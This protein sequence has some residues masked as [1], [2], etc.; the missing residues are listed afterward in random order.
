[1]LFNS[2]EFLLG[3]LPI[4]LG[5]FLFLA[6]RKKHRL[7]IVWMVLASLFFYGWWS[8]KY[9][10][11]IIVSIALNY[12][13]GRLF[14]SPNFQ[15]ESRRK[16]LLILGLIFNLGLLGY[17]KYSNF[18]VNNL[19]SF[20]DFNFEFAEVLLPLAISF[21]TFQQVGF[22]MDSYRNEI[23][24]PNFLNYCFFVTFFPQLIA[25]P[26][27]HHS[28]ILPQL[29]REKSLPSK[30]TFSIGLTLF[31]IGLFKKVIIADSIAVYS[32]QMFDH[33]QAG[34]V[35]GGVGAWVG[36]LCYTF[37]IYF[38]FSG[39]SDM[40]IGLGSLFNIKIPM[41]FN[42]P[43]QASSIIE[44]WRR[45]HIT[46]STFLRDYLYFFLGGNRKGKGRR[47]LNLLA[48]MVLGGLWHGAGWSFIL[49]GALHG[50]YLVINHAIRY[51]MGYGKGK[52]PGR[53]VYIL[54]RI[55]TF[56]A[57][58]IAWVPFR[59]ESLEVTLSIYRGMFGLTSSLVEQTLYDPYLRRPVRLVIILLI[60]S[61]FI[62]NIYRFLANYNPVVGFCPTTVRKMAWRP[63]LGVGIVCGLI[64][65]LTFFE[66]LKVSE[67]LYFQF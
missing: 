18:F 10:I 6:K 40:A 1:M 46:L 65:S 25:G 51:V 43:Y 50:L 34:G 7:G 3:F 57:V 2:Y 59:A 63:T 21:F 16:F 15:E 20:F 27:V 30:E 14:G 55:I 60:M 24:E 23:Q 64:F 37:Q 19:N 9:L 42:S 61:H 41:N 62:P 8:P 58:V 26:I 48:T 54:G 32:T 47:Y 45:W 36:A 38:D 39:Y 13:L 17:Y 31:T 4:C 35:V 22:L 53:G 33:V 66:L 44:F 28:Q 49:W 67:F 12:Q 56:L 11:I 29:D 5:I 52:K